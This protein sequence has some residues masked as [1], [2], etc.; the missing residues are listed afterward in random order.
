MLY[1]A[2]LSPAIPPSWRE[3]GGSEGVRWEAA[4]D[5]DERIN[6]AADLL[7][8]A[9]RT[10]APL[11][12]ASLFHAFGTVGDVY[13]VQER[14]AVETGP[15]GAWKVGAA[16]PQAEPFR[17]PIFR[18]D[19]FES[20]VRAGPARFRLFGIETE[21]AYRL[22]R[23]L[24]A[25]DDPYSVEEALSAFDVMMPVIELVDS[26]LAAGA[27]A[28]P[29]WKL[30]DNQINGGLVLGPPSPGRPDHDPTKQPV[31]LEVA[32]EV[33]VEGRGGNSAGDPRRLLAW[34]VNHTGVHC[35][36]LKAGQIVTTGSLTGLRFVE[37]GQQV[38]ADLEGIG[39]VEVVFT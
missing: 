15:V 7:L 20:P 37:A 36:G 6:K 31:R 1:T 3:A 19:L 4:M 12:D 26:R 10:G 23:D 30:A 35:G 29:D 38:T 24:P 8:R 17:A 39:R 16:S 27:E 32:G 22:A 5:R 13:A 18:A 28:D 9:R 34:M 21:I 2:R 11:D 25:R 14:V 33:V